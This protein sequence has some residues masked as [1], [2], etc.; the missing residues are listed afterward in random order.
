MA[1]WELIHD[2]AGSRRRPQRDGETVNPDLLKGVASI[3]SH[4]G[5]SQR[6]LYRLLSAKVIPAFQ[7]G[8]LWYA[9]KSTLSRYFDT[10]EQSNIARMRVK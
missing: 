4:V 3:A 2:L 1:H 5:L 8:G 7:L 6:Q 10:L 9:R